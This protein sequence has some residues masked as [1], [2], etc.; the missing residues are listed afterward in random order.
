MDQN[1]DGRPTRQRWKITNDGSVTID[2]LI[3]P[4]LASDKGGR[5][6]N[7]AA[8]FRGDHRA[9]TRACIR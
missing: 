6:R 2:F 8:G 9:W 7:I 4:S 1:D 3:Q 5:L